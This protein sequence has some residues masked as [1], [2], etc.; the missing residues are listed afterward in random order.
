MGHKYDRP[1][2]TK[3]ARIRMLNDKN[4]Q[5]YPNARVC[6]TVGITCLPRAD[7]SAIAE[8]V[9]TFDTFNE[10][11][12]PHGEHDFGAFDYKGVRYFWKFDYYDLE[13]DYG[14]EDPSDP[15]QTTRVLTVLR[16]D[17]Y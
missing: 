14:S 11:N 6:F 15:R 7:Q 8:I 4:R 10:D 5:A 12:E 9:Q 17:E 3:V 13:C 2:M 16:A 1:S